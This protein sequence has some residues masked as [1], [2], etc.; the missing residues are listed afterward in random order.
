MPASDS[1]TMPGA[2]A[3]STSTS[4]PR[5]CSS[6]TRR[7]TGKTSAVGLLTWSTKARRVRGVTA[8]S[9]G[10]IT[11]S[12]PAIGNGTGATTTRAP[13]RAATKRRVLRQAA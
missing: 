12:S 11:S 4:T 1:G 3:P 7:S 9:S 5:A 8:A 13:L 6:R 10:A 2:C